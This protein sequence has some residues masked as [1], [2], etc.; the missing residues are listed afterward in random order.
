[1]IVTQRVEIDPTEKQKKVLEVYF[2]YRRYVFNRAL[3]LAKK[4]INLWLQD[5]KLPFFRMC[6]LCE[7][8][9]GLFLCL[10]G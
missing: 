6:R 4:Q 9:D 5:K 8:S 1:M 7:L 3:D 2:G 10:E